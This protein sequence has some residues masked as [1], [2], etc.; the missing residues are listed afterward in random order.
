MDLDKY[1][2]DFDD[3]CADEIYCDNILEHLDF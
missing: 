2:W 3:N 1:P